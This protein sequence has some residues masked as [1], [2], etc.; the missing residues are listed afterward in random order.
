MYVAAVFLPLVGSLISGTLVLFKISLKESGN[1]DVKNHIDLISQVITCASMLLAGVASS[2]VFFEVL[3]NGQNPSIEIFTWVSSGSLQFSWALR[4]DILSVLMVL[5]V[6]VVS[7]MIH[8]YSIGYMATDK[9]IS[10]FMAYL[11]LFTFFMLML[12]SSD[13]L[14]QMF[15]GWEG[16]GL[17]SYLLIGFWY[18][19]PSAN[20]AAIKAF[21]VN[22]I[23]DFGFAL[24]IFAIYFLFDSVVFDTIFNLAQLN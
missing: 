20:K 16:V 6:T 10:R 2:L 12:V 17:A 24:G 13:N 7:S 4:G 21:V 8:V 5:M 3:I 11:S 1:E 23:G 22:R 15:F 14:V 19:R 18:D 9:S